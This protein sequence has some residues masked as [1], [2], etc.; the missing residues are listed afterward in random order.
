MNVYEPSKTS[1]PNPESDAARALILMGVS[2]SGKT[3]VGRA[4]SEAT[5]WPFFDGDDFHPPSNV[6]KMAMDTPLND[7]DRL[8]WLENLHALILEHLSHEQSVI[9][10]SSALKA[11]YRR[12]LDGSRDDIHFVYLRGSY[13]LILSRMQQR[14]DHFMKAGML[15]SQFDDLEEPVNALVVSADASIEAI[16][17]QI[18]AEIFAG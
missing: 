12:I 3:T 14:S 5:G 10:A 16:V 1:G 17:Q 18:L 4:L 7:L 13:N 8:P 9:V 6:K 2:G 15:R 11:A